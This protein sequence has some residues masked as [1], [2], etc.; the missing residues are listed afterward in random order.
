MAR[1][2]VGEINLESV[3]AI[4][5]KQTDDL[6]VL[7]ALPQNIVTLEG[8]LEVNKRVPRGEKKLFYGN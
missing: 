4:A 7:T 8:K 6:G 5:I 3:K 1:Y 2:I